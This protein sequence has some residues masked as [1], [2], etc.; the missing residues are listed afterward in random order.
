MQD[1]PF[2]VYLSTALENRCRR[3]LEKAT[4]LGKGIESSLFE[5][6]E[7]VGGDEQREG[8]EGRV[9]ERARTG[10]VVVVTGK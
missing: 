2:F 9:E 1:G 3:P 6:R 5:K 10:A 7:P 8:G 4:T